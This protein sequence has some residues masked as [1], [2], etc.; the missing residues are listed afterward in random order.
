MKH[1]NSAHVCLGCGT[2]FPNGRNTPD[3]FKYL[4][5]VIQSIIPL[6]AIILLILHFTGPVAAARRVAKAFQKNDTQ[7]V[8]SYLPDFITESDTV[9][10]QS[11]VDD[12]KSGVEQL[13]SS[14]RTFRIY[15]SVNPSDSQL[16]ELVEQIRFF[17]GEDFDLN[18]IKKVK[19][20][21]VKL[22]LEEGDYIRAYD[23]QCLMIKYQGR[24][25]W[26]PYSVID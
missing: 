12:I 21:W 22:S 16:E 9:D 17:A 20:V 14:I 1:T 11:Y 24:W 26:W 15:E 5:I 18:S 3:L 8:V 19:L 10:A 4:R 7:A 13:S 6:T 2:P 23:L 25:H